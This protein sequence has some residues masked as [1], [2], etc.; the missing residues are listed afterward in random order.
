MPRPRPP[1][2]PGPPRRSG[3]SSSM[4]AWISLRWSAVSAGAFTTSG[5]LKAN[6][7]RCC[8][9]ICCKRVICRGI[10]TTSITHEL[11]H[12]L[13]RSFH[14]TI[15]ATQ[16]LCLPR[17]ALLAQRRYVTQTFTLHS[18]RPISSCTSR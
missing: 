5:F 1:G 8:S 4:I 18:D 7:P 6:G 10:N 13:R 15:P 11:P 2:L 17:K 12:L 16:R 9:A 3:D 14:S